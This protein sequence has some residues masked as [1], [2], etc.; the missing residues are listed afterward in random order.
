MHRV[1][2]DLI[3][4][5]IQFTNCKFV[6]IFILYLEKFGIIILDIKNPINILGFLGCF[7][8]IYLIEIVE[9]Y[10]ICQFGL[11]D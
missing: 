7:E 3:K 5:F 4:L 1:I 10:I 11:K 6:C 8:Y 2:I 9:N